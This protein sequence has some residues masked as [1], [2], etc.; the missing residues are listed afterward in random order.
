MC[1]Q[2]ANQWSMSQKCTKIYMLQCWPIRSGHKYIASE[3]KGFRLLDKKV[4]LN[5]DFEP[6]FYS[7]ILVLLAEIDKKLLKRARLFS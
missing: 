4:A 5:C 7:K 2:L 6:S 3:D 1:L